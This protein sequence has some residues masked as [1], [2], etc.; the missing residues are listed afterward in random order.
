MGKV[1]SPSLPF[2]LHPLLNFMDVLWN[3]K[4]YSFGSINFLNGFNLEYRILRHEN[5]FY[6]Y[7]NNIDSI[8]LQSLQRCSEHLR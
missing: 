4:Y 3:C 2:K 7:P 6:S 8:L 5:T 1:L